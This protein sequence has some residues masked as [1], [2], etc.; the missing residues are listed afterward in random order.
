MTISELYNSVAQLGF[1]DSL[2]NDNRFIFAAYRALLQVNALR[3]AM[4]YCLINHNPLKNKAEPSISYP[5]EKTEPLDFYAE[6]V[7]SYYFEATGK[8][9]VTFYHQ[10]VSGE[11][12]LINSFTFDSGVS[13]GF[14]A[15][16]GFIT[17]DGQEISGKIKLT[18]DG[19]FLYFVQNVAMY[20]HLY[21][22]DANDIPAF[23]NYSRYDVSTLAS[24]FLGLMSPPIIEYTSNDRPGKY[25]TDE[26]DVENG[27]TILISNSISGL[28]KVIYKRKPTKITTEILAG[29]NDA[30]IDLDEDLCALLPLLVASYVWVEDEP[31]KAQYYLNLYTERAIDIERR[32][33]EHTPVRMIN[34]TGW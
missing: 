18:F 9:T 20:E 2:E 29:E 3:P 23:G 13:T 17:K 25:L 27:R 28:F 30:L 1:E 7:K 12:E 21:S 19:E 26:Y 15:Y 31:E 4:G 34:V 5:I 10:A 11:W 24:D 8:G 6:N 22:G 33:V 32:K 16:R 14:E